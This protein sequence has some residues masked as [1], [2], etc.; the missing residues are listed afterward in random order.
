MGSHSFLTSAR[1]N[2]ADQAY[3]AA[4]EQA[5]YDYGHDPYNGT[6]STTSG[7][8]MAPGRV[9]TVDDLEDWALDETEKWGDCVCMQ[10]PNDSTRWHFAGWAAS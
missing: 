1:G 2:T 3:R 7:W 8:F 9:R 10:D 6:I 4:V 5:Q